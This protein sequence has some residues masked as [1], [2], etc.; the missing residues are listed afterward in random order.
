[1]SY[2]EYKR[3]RLRAE[4]KIK[5]VR[6]LFYTQHWRSLRAA[7][8]LSILALISQPSHW[9]GSQSVTAVRLESFKKI[10][11]YLFSGVETIFR[12]I[13]LLSFEYI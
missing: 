9:L 2:E 7:S 6:S 10:L 12:K 13:L 5:W 8:G 11:L 4:S 3:Q 1:M